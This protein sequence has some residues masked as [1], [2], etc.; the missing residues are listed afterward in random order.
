MGRSRFGGIL[1]AALL[2]L[3]F[4]CQ[5]M[6]TQRQKP[7]HRTL[8]AVAQAAQQGDWETAEAHLRTAREDWDRFRGLGSVFSHHAPLEGVDAQF[9]ALEILLAGR[10]ELAA[11]TAA[12]LAQQVRALEESHRLTWKNLL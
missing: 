4:W 11:A 5:H 3:G 12:Q 6:L 8:D 1:L 2:V 9:A 10:E 7:I